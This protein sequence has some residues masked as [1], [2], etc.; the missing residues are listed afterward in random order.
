[1]DQRSP[2]HHGMAIRKQAFKAS[3]DLKKLPMEELLSTLKVHEIE[4][5]KDEDQKK[6]KLHGVPSSKV[7]N[8]DP[9]FTFRFWGNLH[10]AIGTKLKLSSTYH[11]Q[12]NNQTK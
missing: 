10:K 9:R 1:M 4:L 6:V 3:K 12:T 8:R 5:N 11:P 7:S 2:N